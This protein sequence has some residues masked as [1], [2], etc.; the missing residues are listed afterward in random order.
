MRPMRVAPAVVQLPLPA[1]ADDPVERWW[2]LPE[3]S[4]AQVLRILAGL[5]A[6]GVLIDPGP[7]PTVEASGGEGDDE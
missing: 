5:I 1:L 2:S 3:T 7:A 4:R 6:R